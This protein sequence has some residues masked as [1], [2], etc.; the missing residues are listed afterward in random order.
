MV[1]NQ[2]DNIANKENDISDQNK[3]PED[4]S[5]QEEQIIENNG[6]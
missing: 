3:S 4:V 6:S 2:S 1:E 5:S